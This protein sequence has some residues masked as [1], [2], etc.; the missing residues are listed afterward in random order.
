MSSE[1]DAALAAETGRPPDTADVEVNS[2]LQEFSDSIV[3]Q[4]EPGVGEKVAAAAAAHQRL[5]AILTAD[6]G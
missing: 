3:A 6:R 2:A 4:P 5:Q 1:S